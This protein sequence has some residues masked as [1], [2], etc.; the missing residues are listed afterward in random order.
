MKKNRIKKSIF[1]FFSMIF[2]FA[3]LFSAV[4]FSGNEKKRNMSASA[5]STEVEYF[6]NTGNLVSEI[7]ASGDVTD[8]KFSL[9]DY[10]PLLAE[11]QLN[12]NLCWVYSSMKSLESSLMVQ[13]GE[14]YNFS[15]VGT[16]YLSYY[17]GHTS[18][19]FGS[20]NF[21]EDFCLV[22][23]NYGLVYENDI[24]NDLMM[25]M[26]S[27]NYQNFKY[28]LDYTNFDVINSVKPV[29]IFDHVDY[30]SLGFGSSN[31]AKAMFIKNYIKKY[32]GLFAGLGEGTAYYNT[33]L[34][35]SL[36]TET[37]D[38][39]VQIG[40]TINS[41]AVCI[42]GWDDEYGFLALNSWGVEYDY[43]QHFY[44][45]F[46]SEYFYTTL[47]GFICN[48]EKQG[49]NLSNS[50]ATNFASSIRKDPSL[51]GLPK[52]NNMFVY[53]EKISLSFN[54]PESINGATL[55]TEVYKGEIDV[56]DKFVIDVSE[57]LVNFESIDGFY[58]DSNFYVGGTY[59][60]KFYS[61]LDYLSSKQ[62]AIF[63][64]TE[65][66]YFKFTGGSSAD[67]TTVILGGFSN[68]SNSAT[69]Y[70]NG[71]NSYNLNMYLTTL[72]SYVNLK[73][74]IGFEKG[75]IKIYSSQNGVDGDVL[76]SNTLITT[77]KTGTQKNRGY[78]VKIGAFLTQIDYM[79]EFSVKITSPINSCTRE[80]F[81]KLYISGEQQSTANA[82]KIVYR[83][84]GG[85][86]SVH[87]PDGFANYSVDPNMTEITLSSPIKSNCNFMGWYLEP[88]F[89]TQVS[90]IDATFTSD[91]NGLIVLYAK[92]DAINEVYFDSS[93][94]I[95]SVTDYD[96]NKKDISSNYK[97]VYGDTVE[98][99]YNIVATDALSAYPNYIT[100]YV[101]SVNGKSVKEDSITLQ[102]NKAS[103][104]FTL[105]YPDLV[106]GKY[107]IKLNVLMIIGHSFN[108]NSEDEN[109]FDVEK[110]QVSVSFENLNHV[111]DGTSVLP[112]VKLN[113]IYKEDKEKVKTKLSR[114]EA[115]N[116]G[117]Y[118][119]ELLSIGN[120]NYI[121]EESKAKLNIEKRQLTLS[122][123][124]TQST[125]NGT[126]QLPE[127][128][129]NNLV[130]GET[131]A[132]VMNTE[133]H[134]DVGEY[135]IS[136][137]RLT[138]DENYKLS[139]NSDDVCKFKINPAKITVAFDNISERL[140]TSSAYR[141]QIT[142]KVVS[143]VLYANDKLNLTIS[144]EGLTAE[145]SG[146]YEI[147]S[148]YN[149]NNYEV[150]FINAN[151]TL[152]GFY[153]V[154]YTLPNG[155]VHIEELTDGEKPKGINSSIYKLPPL[156]SY[157]YNKPLENIGEDL[158]I[159]VTVNSNAW[160]FIV[161]GVIVSFV[162]I[163]LVIT[164]KARRNKVG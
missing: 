128:S 17:N 52:L 162:V 49:L 9:E 73:N 135:D 157:S 69:F 46:D 159:K 37:V 41:H 72:N 3:I 118:E 137:V 92:W 124:K 126:P 136:V 149:N 99:T 83:T 74:D 77:E 80:I 106:S 122:W 18:S 27:L 20:N 75:N 88:E 34:D 155:K 94:E 153:Y 142:Y 64:G 133:G 91:K 125:Y 7:I 1:V 138:S 31:S 139:S 79:V 15:E 110:K 152:T 112:T 68:S 117:E 33:D 65:V 26:T 140:Q 150:T 45:P 87:N 104:K 66:S 55:Y 19:L 164:R 39:D 146:V 44:I 40:K 134:K 147:S 81:F 108:V 42:V 160:L 93:L 51:V 60:I 22:S 132:L 13:K 84:N 61:G 78:L 103:V 63:T 29:K 98:L 48:E 120:E 59:V 116:A 50:S 43:Q 107:N 85:E 158:Y 76:A 101:F 25:Y 130:E 105:G 102:D 58:S 151:Y 56:T 23:Q 119:F 6:N 67:T 90:K 127:Y 121:F 143:G 4:N 30:M 131:C 163:Y 148:T 2:V 97:I 96:G 86:N 156:C 35:V 109:N 10:Y 100:Y 70:L 38:E 115:T 54:I 53:N 161:A 123:T 82:G 21:F 36:Y 141:K 144:C 89:K 24:S 111:Y 12:S 28:V 62:F 145:E 5:T 113:G 32:G 114:G 129:F 95:T 16:A 71:R 14:Y 57:N 47:E 11:N 8:S 154:Y